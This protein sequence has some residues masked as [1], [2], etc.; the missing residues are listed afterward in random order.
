MALNRLWR[1]PSTASEMALN[2]LWRWHSTASG[3]DA[4]TTGRRDLADAC[5]MS[6]SYESNEENLCANGLPL[7]QGQGE[8]GLV[9]NQRLVHAA[10][11]WGP[12]ISRSSAD[13]QNQIEMH[14]C[15]TNMNQSSSILNPRIPH[16]SPRSRHRAINCEAHHR[17]VCSVGPKN[18]HNTV[19]QH[20]AVY[21]RPRLFPPHERAPNRAGPWAA[22]SG[23]V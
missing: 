8:F 22:I 18:S 19:D 7:K 2:R 12:V 5:R 15:W 11:L 3:Q 1:W 14:H 6:T 4:S 23:T 16:A 17:Q 9:A 21:D 20:E 10:W 13:H